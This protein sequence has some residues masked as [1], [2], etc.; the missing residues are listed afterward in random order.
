MTKHGYSASNVSGCLGISTQVFMYG[1]RKR[2]VERT[3]VMEQLKTLCFVRMPAEVGVEAS[4][5]RTGTRHSK[6]GIRVNYAFMRDNRIEF[7]L[8]LCDVS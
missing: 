3:S 6:K 1:L 8:L 7:E 4:R 5:G 2:V